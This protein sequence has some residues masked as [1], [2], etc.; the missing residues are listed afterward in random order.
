MSDFT[1]DTLDR[2]LDQQPSMREALLRDPLQRAQTEHLRTLLDAAARAMAAEGVSEDAQ[3]R[4]VNRIV[5]GGP[6]G[7]IDEHGK[8]FTL[9]TTLADLPRHSL[10]EL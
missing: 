3:R 6:E 5:W 1:D 2:Y 9:L 8:R 4:V 7:R 10:P